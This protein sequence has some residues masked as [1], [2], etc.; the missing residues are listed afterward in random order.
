MSM[1]RKGKSASFYSCIILFGLSKE[2]GSGNGKLATAVG[3]EI[4]ILVYVLG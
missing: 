4:L 1:Q 2:N 3:C